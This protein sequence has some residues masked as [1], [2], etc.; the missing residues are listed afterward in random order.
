MSLFPGSVVK[1]GA[2]TTHSAEPHPLASPGAAPVF[3]PISNVPWAQAG[4]P[5]KLR[6]FWHGIACIGAGTLIITLTC[7][8]LHMVAWSA[9]RCGRRLTALRSIVNTARF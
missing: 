1:L 8:P 3:E 2:D 6:G 5:I 9:R 7:D 4:E